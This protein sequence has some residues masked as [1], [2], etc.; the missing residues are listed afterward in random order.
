MWNECKKYFQKN[1]IL[2][3]KVI[4]EKEELL[5]NKNGTHKSYIFIVGCYIEWR[6]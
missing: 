1:I 4:D 5:Y 2:Q 3:K 6:R